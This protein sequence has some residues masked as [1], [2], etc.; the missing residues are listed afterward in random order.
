M[1][2]KKTPTPTLSTEQSSKIL[3]VRKL[4]ELLEKHDLTEIKLAEKDS[5]I[6]L[7]S[8]HET[9]GTFTQ[10]VSAPAATISTE[11][12]KS[13]S[14]D[15]DNCYIQTSPFIGTFYT[16]P[17]P[18]A[19]PFVKV[20]SVISEGQSL[21]IVEAM[22]LMNEIE[23]DVTGTLVAILAENQQSVEYGQPLFK[24]QIN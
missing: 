13:S 24:I 4:A 22:K 17:S 16:A 1:P 7:R 3:M 20:G 11:A 19:E 21:C 18:D 12:D 10:P 5:S 2:S 15:D 23:S 14:T 8:N 6:V 9:I